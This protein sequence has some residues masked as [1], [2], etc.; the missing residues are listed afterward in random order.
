[1]AGE[2]DRTALAID[3]GD[4]GLA[5]FVEAPG[6]CEAEMVHVE[7]ERGFDVGHGEDGAREPVGHGWGPRRKTSSESAQFGRW[8]AACRVP[9]LGEHPNSVAMRL[10]RNWDREL[11]A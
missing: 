7:A 5:G 9:L 11:L 1:M 6:S 3:L 4:V 10:R 8:A 2:D